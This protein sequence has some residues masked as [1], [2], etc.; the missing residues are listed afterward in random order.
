MDRDEPTTRTNW[1]WWRADWEA[2]RAELSQTNWEDRL[3]GTLNEQVE[4]FT[5]HLL[6]LQSKYVPC[7]TYKS[8]P[9]DQPEEQGLATTE[10][11]QHPS[12]LR[13]IYSCLL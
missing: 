1:L 12:Q 7:Q 3:T 10:S 9:G 2:L 13:G 4:A 11:K 5:S 8:R 6:T